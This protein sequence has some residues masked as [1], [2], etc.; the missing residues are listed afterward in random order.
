MSNNAIS[1]RTL[2]NKPG[3]VG[4]L[5]A[6]SVGRLASGLVPF[7]LMAIFAQGEKFMLAGGVSAIFMLVTSLSG[8]WLGHDANVYC[9]LRWYSEFI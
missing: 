2:L 4:L 5:F 1:Y 7:G 6:V 8:P 9:G 3:F